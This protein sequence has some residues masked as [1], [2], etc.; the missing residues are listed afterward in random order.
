MEG[1]E[2]KELREQ[3]WSEGLSSAAWMEIE[4]KEVEAAARH[5]NG[6]GGWGVQI[7]AN[8]EDLIVWLYKR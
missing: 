8:D 2:N 6:C 7:K 1:R 3:G 4:K 5:Y